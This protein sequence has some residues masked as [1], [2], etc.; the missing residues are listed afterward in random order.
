[1]DIV[2][3]IF[4]ASLAVLLPL[5]AFGIN[6]ATKRDADK[7]RPV[8]AYDETQTIEELVASLSASYPFEATESKFN[9]IYKT[10]ASYNKSSELSSLLKTESQLSELVA[11][12]NGERRSTKELLRLATSS[13]SD[14][15]LNALFDR[16]KE[17]KVL[18]EKLSKAM[19]LTRVA[20]TK[21]AL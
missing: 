4:F 8:A 6:R 11:S 7:L 9:E 20:G 10:V 18:A 1:M 3:T 21:L 15:A 13:P 2:Y 12:L 5:L 16:L 14:A 17:D 19:S